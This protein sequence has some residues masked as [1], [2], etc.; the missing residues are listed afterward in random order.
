M[1][2]Q[3]QSQLKNPPDVENLTPVPDKFAVD[4]VSSPLQSVA[5]VRGLNKSCPKKLV[6][7]LNW[8][9][10][11]VASFSFIYIVLISGAQKQLV[12]TICVKQLS[13]IRI[14]S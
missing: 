4:V 12:D 5:A 6:A 14:A 7:I 8:D 13:T 9:R 2:V 3:S 11:K 10:E 1:S